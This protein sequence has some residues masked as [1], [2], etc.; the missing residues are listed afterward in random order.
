MDKSILILRLYDND[1]F[2][3]DISQVKRYYWCKQNNIIFRICRKFKIPFLKIFFDKWKN[4]ISQFDRVILFD[5]GYHPNIAK[6]IRK[7]NKNAKI[8]LWYWNPLVI[9]GQK[10]FKD[11]NVDEVWTYNR[12]DAQKLGIKYNSQFYHKIDMVN[13]REIESDVI[14]LGRDKNRDN[15]IIDIKTTLEKYKI[16]C[17]FRVIRNE[18]EYVTYNEYLNEILSCR[19]IL[20]FNVTS[21]NGLTL[22]PLEALFLKKKLITNNKDIINYDFYRPNNIFVLDVD[23]MSKIKEFIESPYEDIDEDIVN[24]YDFYEWLQRFKEK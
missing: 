2:F 21:L 20:D 22:R 18:N 14:F 9:N 5:N 19:C 8:I 24:Y 6:Y 1:M 23:D 4:N 16:K 17:N 12:F 10:V 11:K 3:S 7:K 15:G 13:N